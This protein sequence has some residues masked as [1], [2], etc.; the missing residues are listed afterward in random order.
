MFGEAVIGEQC[1]E[2]GF[3]NHVLRQHLN[4]FF[5]ADSVVEV[6]AQFGSK[7]FKGGALCFIGRVFQN[8]VDTVNMGT[9]DFGNVARPVF[10]MVTVATFFDNF[11]VEGAFD[12]SDFELEGF[13]YGRG[14]GGAAYAVASLGFA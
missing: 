6:V 2:H 1:V 11:C 9:G 8:G 13:L 5:V 10:P 7:G 3:G 14:C 12:F 4:D